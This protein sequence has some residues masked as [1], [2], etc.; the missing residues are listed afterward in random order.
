MVGLLWFVIARLLVHSLLFFLPSSGS[1]YP[2]K[3]KTLKLFLL[4]LVHLRCTIDC[5]M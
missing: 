5:I 3:T 4:T 1:I 2:R